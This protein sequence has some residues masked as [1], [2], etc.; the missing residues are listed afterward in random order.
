MIQMPDLIERWSNVHRVLNAMPEHERLKHWDMSTWGEATE[1]GTVACAAGHCGLDP[2]FRE[3]G[4]RLDVSAASVEI[5]NVTEFFGLEGSERIFM[6]GKLRPVET[7]IEEVRGYHDELQRSA[8]L[9]IGAP[10]IGALWTEQGGIY[11]GVRPG[12]NGAPYYHLIVG[13]E[14][15]DALNWHDATAWASSLAI[16]GHSDYALPLPIEQLALF[17]R[18]RRLFKRD[19]YWSGKQHESD[20][21]DAYGQDFSSGSQSYWSKASKLR[22]RLVRRLAIQ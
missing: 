9:M 14:H 5:S 1:C 3:R 15:D 22:A 7:V 16:D 12:L 2:W 8:A 11:A 18:V 4:F 17:D 19:V 20:S 6:N 13:A 21:D 10:E